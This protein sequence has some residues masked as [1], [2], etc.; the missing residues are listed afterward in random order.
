MH[1]HMDVKD[2]AKVVL[3]SILTPLYINWFT[4]FSEGSCAKRDFVT[5]TD[6]K[7][8]STKFPVFFLASGKGIFIWGMIDMKTLLL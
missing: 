5:F 2:H 1:G 6:T 7:V 4:S 3:Y 8:R